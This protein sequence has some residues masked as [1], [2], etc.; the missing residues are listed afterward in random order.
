MFM[1]KIE[2]TRKIL[3]PTAMC[4]YL[5]SYINLVDSKKK[6][7]FKRVNRFSL[8]TQVQY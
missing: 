6:N 5:L 4:G 2:N 7:V 1:E 8:L 3:W